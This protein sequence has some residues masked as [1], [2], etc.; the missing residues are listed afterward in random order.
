MLLVKLDVLC[1]FD[2]V[3]GGVG[4]DLGD[5]RMRLVM[6]RLCEL[7]I[8]VVMLCLMMCSWFVI[9]LLEFFCFLSLIIVISFL[10]LWLGIVIVV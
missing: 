5:I 2:F 9:F 1:L 6:F 8:V 4:I 7:N 3:V 10:V